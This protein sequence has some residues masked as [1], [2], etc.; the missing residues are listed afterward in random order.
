ML[1][2]I[3]R[4]NLS[5]VLHPEFFKDGSATFD[6]DELSR[7]KSIADKWVKRCIIR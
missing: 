2:A 1:Y 4:S 7:F 3:Q 5:R 6:D